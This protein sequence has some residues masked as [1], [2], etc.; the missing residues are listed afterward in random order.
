MSSL[1]DVTAPVFY[2]A[3]DALVNDT[4]VISGSEGKHAAT[5]RRLQ[6]GEPIVV[7]DGLGRW[8]AGAVQSVE[9]R[10]RVIVSVHQ[11]GTDTRP[12]PRIVVVQ[13]VPKGDRGETAVE[14]LT[15]VGVDVITPWI[16]ERTQLRLDDERQAKLLTRWRASAREAAKQA[17]RTWWPEVNDVVRRQAALDVVRSAAVA[18]VLDAQAGTAIA[19]MSFDVAGDIAVVIGPEGGLTPAEITDLVSVGATPVRLGT[20]VLRTSTAGTVAAGV[21]LSRTAR[22]SVDPA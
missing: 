9:K 2:A 13:A 4:V 20:S 12:T 16:S 15:E 11:R 21:V 6:I 1:R 22:W 14:T 3:S 17:R 19:D 8:V 18:L 5:V 7:T 10:D